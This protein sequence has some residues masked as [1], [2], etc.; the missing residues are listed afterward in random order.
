MNSLPLCSI[1]DVRTGISLR[2]RD[3]T[4]PDP[5]GSLQIVRISDLSDDGE[6]LSTD[7]VRFEP[8]ETIQGKYVLRLGDVLFPNRGTRTTA[9]MW[10]LEHSK[11]IAGAQFYIIRTN[12]PQVLPAYLAW[13]LRTE[14]AAAYFNLFRKG[15]L[16]QTIEHGDISDL[17]IP[18]PSLLKQAQIV[19]L[20]A[21]SI[22]E[23]KLSEKLLQLK[24]TYAQHQ[25]FIA[26]SKVH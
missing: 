15:T 7:L 2:G 18:L 17:P 11:A 9:H 1:A 13:Y 23:R 6:L 22:E 14:E 21:L 8:K 4:R 12:S 16:V 3:A 20:D 19:T 26:A 10:N 5:N 25:L 24:F